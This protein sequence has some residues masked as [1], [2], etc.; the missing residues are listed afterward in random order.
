M[1]E[2]GAATNTG[3]LS[4]FLQVKL[5]CEMNQVLNRCKQRNE[6]CQCRID[7]D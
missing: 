5:P 7:E 2:I 6:Q 1:N 3:Y 4:K